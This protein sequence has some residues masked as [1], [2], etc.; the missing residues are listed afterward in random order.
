MTISRRALLRAL[1]GIAL[2]KRLS[3]TD[4][5]LT[6]SGLRDAIVIRRDENGIPY[7]DAKN[8]DDAFFGLGFCQ[9]QDR[10]FQIELYMRLTRGTLSELVGEIDGRRQQGNLSSAIRLFVLDY[11]RSRTLTPSPELADS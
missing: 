1:L 8:D 7:V 3:T 9:A 6:V 10:A 11:F 5:S 2:G 4:G